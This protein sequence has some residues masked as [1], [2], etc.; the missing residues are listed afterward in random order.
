MF[1]RLNLRTVNRWLDSDNQC[2][3]ESVLD[4][5]RLGVAHHGGPGKAKLFVR[6]TI[7]SHAL[8]RAVI[9]LDTILKVRFTETIP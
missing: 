8:H 4:R 3:T 6:Q 2:W 9:M 7:E 1:A 5:V